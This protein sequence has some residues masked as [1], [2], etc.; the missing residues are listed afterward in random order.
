MTGR[1]TPL[2]RHGTK[3]FLKRLK[4]GAAGLRHACRP[5]ILVV[6]AGAVAR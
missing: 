3:G 6:A 5:E 4:G 1:G 2:L